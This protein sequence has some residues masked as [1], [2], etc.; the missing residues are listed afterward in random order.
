M[1]YVLPQSLDIAATFTNDSSGI[2]QTQYLVF[3]SN[4]HALIN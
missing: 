4:C 2:L 3:S 1:T